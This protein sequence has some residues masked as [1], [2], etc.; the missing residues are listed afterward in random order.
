MWF[1]SSI[2][3][4]KTYPR[5]R[6]V[7]KLFLCCISLTKRD[8]VNK[9]IRLRATEILQFFVALSRI[10]L[11]TLASSF[12]KNMQHKNAF[13]KTLSLGDVFSKSY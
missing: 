13:F 1:A 4:E 10:F 5:L 6:F 9:N 11:L 7:K 12:V 3:L 8:A 2:E